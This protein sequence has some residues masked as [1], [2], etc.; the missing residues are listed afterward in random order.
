MPR[1]KF[2]G[3]G[4]N[5]VGVSTGSGLYVGGLWIAGPTGIALISGNQS[6]AV[7]NAVYGFWAATN[8]PLIGVT[9]VTNAAG[10]AVLVPIL[11]TGTIHGTN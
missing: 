10:V 1:T 2:V 4:T 7:T 8:Y 6:N 3:I 11:G 5:L 9:V